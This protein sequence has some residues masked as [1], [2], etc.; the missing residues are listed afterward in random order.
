MLAAAEQRGAIKALRDAAD[1][2]FG[3]KFWPSDW[4][5]KKADRRWR[6]TMTDLPGYYM[7]HCVN[8]MAISHSAHNCPY[9]DD[10]GPNDDR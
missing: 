2:S 6:V 1:E 5:N 10:E 8:C 7:P 3:F 9:N 4:L